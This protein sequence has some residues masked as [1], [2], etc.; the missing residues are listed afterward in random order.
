MRKGLILIAAAATLGLSACSPQDLLVE[1][2][3]SLDKGDFGNS[4]LNNTLVHTGELDAAINLTRKFAAEAPNTINFEFDKSNLDAEARSALVQQAAWIKQYPYVKFRVYGH[5][6]LVGSSAYNQS[7]GLRRARA[8][9]N[10][11]VS[12]GISRSRLEAVASFGETR[13]LVMTE[14]RERRNRRTVTEVS[15]FLKG[16]PQIL[17][18]KYA[19][20]IYNTYV[21]SSA[22]AAPGATGGQ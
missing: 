19:A 18:G 7:L 11:L 20:R 15:G 4:T 21:G 16:R 22:E 14:A 13:P 6:D 9:V 17:D 3:G 1:A 2:G 10:F 8:A 12:Q 5:T